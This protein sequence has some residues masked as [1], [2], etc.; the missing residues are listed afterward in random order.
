MIMDYLQYT[1]TKWDKAFAS[2]RDNIL[3]YIP[4]IKINVEHIG[5]TSI[6]NCRSFRNVDIL[7]SVHNFVDISTVSM[8]L[9]S[10][11]YKELKE[12]SSIDCVVLVKKQKVYGCGITVRVVEYASMLYR[13]IMAFKAI[14]RS[15]FDR[16]ILYNQFRETLFAKNHKDIKKYNEVKYAY[17]NGLV[18]ERYKFE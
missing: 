4:N 3:F 9:Q 11:D 15:S 14:L 12:L 16:T 17:I 5:A 8:L 6:P 10:K 1:P 2:E 13:K 18:D 7:V